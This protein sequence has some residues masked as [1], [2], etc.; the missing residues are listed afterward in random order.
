M[1]LFSVNRRYFAPSAL[2]NLYAITWGAAPGYYISR[3]WRWKSGGE[4]VPG[5][6][7]QVAEIFT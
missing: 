7:I 6:H 3:L 5:F 4:V 2:Q 1:Q